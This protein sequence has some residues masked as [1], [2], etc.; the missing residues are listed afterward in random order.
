MTHRSFLAGIPG[1]LALA[2]AAGSL[3]AGALAA[4]APLG[5]GCH[6]C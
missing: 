6:L 2:V 5:G 3:A 4:G 1:A